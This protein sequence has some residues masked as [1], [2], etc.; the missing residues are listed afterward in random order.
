MRGKSKWVKR[1]L[2]TIGCT[3]ILCP[4]ARVLG[5]TSSLLF[6]APTLTAGQ[7][8]SGSFDILMTGTAATRVHLSGESIGM[9]I[10]GSGVQF[11]ATDENT[12]TPYVFPDSLVTDTGSKLDVTGIAYPKSDFLTSDLSDAPSSVVEI[13]DGDTFGVVHVSYTVDPGAALGDR[14]LTFE[15]VPLDTSATDEL[16]NEIPLTT[17]DGV[18]TV[19]AVPEPTCLGLIAAGGIFALSRRRR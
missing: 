2:G 1:T 17:T 5:D 9:T 7:G 12:A 19:V 6:T 3:A 11:T 8:S 16:G 13:D 15:A 4:A 10:S 18:L 14:T